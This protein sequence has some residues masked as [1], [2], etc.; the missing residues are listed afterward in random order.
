MDTH[1]SKNLADSEKIKKLA[2]SK[3]IS[4]KSVL[5]ELDRRIDVLKWFQYKGIRE[6]R[7]LGA[8]FE[9]YRR[10]PEHIYSKVVDDIEVTSG[11]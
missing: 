5:Q 11:V 1:K 10:N 8:M 3:G 9:Q 6:F 7:E 4:I 2:R